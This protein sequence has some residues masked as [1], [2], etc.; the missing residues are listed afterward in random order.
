MSSI[1]LTVP[2][3]FIPATLFPCG[4]DASSDPFQKPKRV[5]ALKK[6]MLASVPL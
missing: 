1:E 2:N 4:A 5:C 3:W 6:A